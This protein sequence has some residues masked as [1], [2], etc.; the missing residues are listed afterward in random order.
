MCRVQGRTFPGGPGLSLC[1]LYLVYL[2]VPIVNPKGDGR[3]VEQQQKF[4]L[5][6]LLLQALYG[7]ALPLIGFL[8]GWR[9]ALGFTHLDL[10]LT[11][12]LS[13]PSPSCHMCSSWF[14]SRFPCLGA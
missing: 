1:S 11:Q 5:K 8:W 6:H 4:I 13:A 3:R 10:Q 9:V 12:R 2:S 14:L 7:P